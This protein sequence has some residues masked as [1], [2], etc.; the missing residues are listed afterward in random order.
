VLISYNPKI[1]N[2]FIQI[3]RAGAMTT[4]KYQ[5]PPDQSLMEDIGAT[6]FTL[7]EA[8]VELVANCI[9]ARPLNAEGM[10]SKNLNIEI[11][12]DRDSV[13]I[14]DDASGMTEDIL[15]QAVRL[16]AKMD[17]FLGSRKRKGMYGLGLKTAAAS[18]G[19]YWAIYTR[20]KDSSDDYF[21]EFNLETYGDGTDWTVEVESEP[22][23]NK[24]ILGDRESGT[25]VVIK[26]IR[27][28]EHDP[29]AVTLLLGNAYGPHIDS[30]DV[31]KVNG[32]VAA[33]SQYNF[34]DGEHIEFDEEIGKSL[35]G[36]RVKGWVGID[37]KTHNDGSYGFNLFREN[38]LIET[39]DKSWFRAHLMTSRIVGV[40]HMDFMPVNFN[41]QGFKTQSE[42]WRLTTEHM[43]EYLKPVVR[44][45]Q[46]ASRGKGDDK[47]RKRAIEG[48]MKAMK[49]LAGIDSHE[50]DSSEN[51]PPPNGTTDKNDTS[52]KV[53]VT[54]N[55]IRVNGHELI[56]TYITEDLDSELTPWDYVYSPCGDNKTE[57]QAVLNSASLLYKH[58]S[59]TNILGLLAQTD[60]VTRYLVERCGLNPTDAREIRDKWVYASLKMMDVKT[61]SAA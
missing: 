2:Q 50:D 9:D 30:G 43:R 52:K 54:A 38:Q 19:R 28:K 55:S 47:K 35:M 4:K 29:S 7:A 11:S 25:A 16:G 14:L 56:P 49:G 20:S 45:S 1:N 17:K 48:M 8:V 23:N 60:C 26:K 58:S 24:S 34:K 44:A 5:I 41:K 36:W 10:P 40:A 15:V 22:K 31:I 59:D 57:V 27:D 3:E 46:D 32:V 53:V 37:A 6:S 18:I 13:V 12:I 33:P 39:W 21:L 61:E 42:E 51:P